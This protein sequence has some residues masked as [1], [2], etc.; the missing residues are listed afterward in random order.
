[1]LSEEMSEYVA[2]LKR[3]YPAISS[4]WLFGSRADGT[5]NESSDW[6]L[7]VFSKEPVL[8]DIKTEPRFHLENVDL[9]L[10][11]DDGE[12]SKPFGEP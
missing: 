9:L 1:M 8:E 10:V 3:A 2:D 12:F 4:M 7:F 6:D 11:G 5:A